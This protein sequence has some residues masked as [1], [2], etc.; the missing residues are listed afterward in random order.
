MR[1]GAGPG[2]IRGVGSKSGEVPRCDCEIS[3]F[4]ELGSL[5]FNVP[6]LGAGSL[7]AA[8]YLGKTGYALSRRAGEA[9]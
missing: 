4:L 5:N 3:E 8:S 6:D 7:F 1:P 2:R 9:N